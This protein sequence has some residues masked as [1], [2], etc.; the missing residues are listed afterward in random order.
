MVSLLNGRTAAR[1][2]VLPAALLLALAASQLFAQ[3]EQFRP[4][5]IEFE[6]IQTPGVS[7]TLLEDRNGFIWFGTDIGLWR[8]DG[9]DFKNYSHIV[10]ERIDTGMYQDRQGLIWIGTEG[11]LIAFN[12]STETRTVYRHDPQNPRTLSNSVF[13]YK[14][15]AFCE[16]PKGRLWIAT[17]EGLNLYDRESGDFQAFTKQKGGL[18]DNYIT[19]VIPSK[20]GLLWVATIRG[21]QKFDPESRKVVR[22]FPGAPLNMY[23]LAEDSIGRLW[24]GTYMDGVYRLDPLS[25]AFV[26]YR[27]DSHDARSLSSDVVTFIFVTHNVSDL[28]WIATFD[29]GLDILDPR[30]GD[31]VRYLSN[32]ESASEKGISGNALSHII[33]DRM[34]ALLVLNEH[35]FLNRIDPDSRRF[36][37]LSCNASGSFGI[38]KAS[39]YNV[40]TDKSG[41]VW[42]LAGTKKIGKYNSARELFEPVFEFPE[43][44][45]GMIVA[46]KDG[47]IWM[48][49]NGAISQ[50]DPVARAIVKTISV[51]GFRLN[52]L[53]DRSD[54]D[55][56]WLGSANVGIVKVNKLS[57]TVRYIM[58][59]SDKASPPDARQ[60]LMRLILAQDD[61]GFLWLSTFGVGLQKF[62]PRTEKIVDT[63]IPTDANLGNP[64]GLFRDSK[65]RYW[66]SFQ[67]SGPAR[68]DLETGSFSRF[69]SLAEK[70][71]PA[72]GSTGILEDNDGRLWISGN[73][74]GEIVRFDPETNDV[75]IYN[76]IDGV[77]PG[78]SDTLNGHPVIGRD[79]AFW[80]S[81]MGGVTR[82]LPGRIVDNS[83]RPPVYIT[84]FDHDG[85][86]IKLNGAIESTREVTLVQGQNSFDFEAVA[87]NYRLSEK[88]RYQFRLIGRDNNWFD[89]GTRR[90]GHYSGLDEGM[91]ILE[92]KGSN[93]DGVW[94]ETPARLEIYV[95]PSIPKEAKLYS[96]EDIMR[97]KASNPDGDQSIVVFEA[98]PLDFNA[99]RGENYRYRLDGYDSEWMPITSRRFISY[100]K[101]PVGRY[102]FRIRNEA[103]SEEH[104]LGITIKPP[105]F[106]SWWFISI[107][108][109]IF[110]FITGAFIRQK[111]LYLKH[112]REEFQRHQEEE[113][114]LTR[115]KSEAIDARLTAIAARENAIEALQVSEK[116]HRELLDTMA[117][118][119]AISDE[120]D[121]LTYVNG[122]FCEML[123]YSSD[124]IIGSN[125]T[126]FV[127]EGSLDFLAKNG[128]KLRE[129]EATT[130]ELRLVRA[131]GQH[132]TA[133]ISSRPLM[134]S[135]GH[136]SESF[137]VITDIS[138]LKQTEASLRSRE[139]ELTVEKSS[140]EE[141]NTTLNVLLKKREEAVEEVRAGVQH[142]LKS[143][144]LPY[145]E[146]LGESGLDERQAMLA[147]VITANLTDIASK[148]TL[149]IGS[150]YAGL[151]HSESE[152]LNLI[153][154]GKQTKEIAR[155]LNIS[156]RTVEFHRI[157]IREKL[158]LKGK[159][160]DLR[161]YP[162]E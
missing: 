149:N 60:M 75:R 23:A 74:S 145:M 36:T 19:A 18:I 134:N 29:G 53:S 48:A 82:F 85:V 55:V 153:K 54:P 69:E 110:L 118:G 46:D 1:R 16:D 31:I 123:G 80:F 119:F 38:P 111:V 22:Y 140:L 148:I 39:V 70:I 41:T 51:E 100:Q 105:F 12:P 81:G 108:C 155:I 52:G 139:Q 146:K 56:L 30:T 27:K 93:N 87:L 79:G 135:K 159:R 94:N 137:A 152:V 127:H 65:G 84:A 147:D 8:Y 62:D 67:N 144:V 47:T 34:G 90:S 129:G 162:L 59:K 14:K 158:G 96:L 77:A 101:L 64:S 143:L 126:S 142:D 114:Q 132:L 92:V 9:Y 32:P 125:F 124:K 35:G 151:T 45:N 15:H 6:K 43:S 13:Q 21:L 25:G 57:R 107:V 5:R 89:A 128:T 68:F 63:Y 91:Y 40:W 131:D 95:Q 37:K 3:V 17:D 136:L 103:S 73:G 2:K 10:P 44:T 120:L 86:S 122:R 104:A 156:E 99:F 24:I 88:N 106:R 138:Q 66:V 154:D 33:M 115:E 97:G 116:R 61:N 109:M 113:L 28:I 20:D 102:T 42:I 130:F 11:G 117:E 72:C 133:L 26:Q 49:G 7:N 112:E 98:A 161:S 50:F 160:I 157:N 78:T 71:W 121:T 141:I 83:Y 150:R 58:P 76:Q 4:D